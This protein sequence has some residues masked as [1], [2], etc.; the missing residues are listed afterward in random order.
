MVSTRLP[1]NKHVRVVLI[2][3][4]VSNQARKY[5]NLVHHIVGLAFAGMLARLTPTGRSVVCTMELN[6]LLKHLLQC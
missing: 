2:Y 4:S 3:D 6:L 5:L 1:V